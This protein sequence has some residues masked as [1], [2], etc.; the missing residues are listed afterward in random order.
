MDSNMDP[1]EK[2]IKNKLKKHLKGVTGST[3]ETLVNRV[4][5][6][7]Y[8]RVLLIT[9]IGIALA[10]NNLRAAV[11]MLKAAPEVSRLV[12]GSDMRVWGE[13]GKRLSATSADAAI[14]F[15]RASGDTLNVIVEDMR[16][17]VLRLVNKQAALS[18]NT[19]V[20]SFKSAPEIIGSIG[21]HEIVAQVL[22]ICLELARH[23]VKHS[24]DL[25]LD[26]PRVLA[27]LRS[28]GRSEGDAQIKRA[29]AL[30]S[31]FA[32]RSGGTAAEF[33]A[34]LPQVTA[35][36]GGES[37]E[38]LF[39]ITEQ[40][41]DRSGGVALQYFKAAS[42]VLAVAGHDSFE[43]WSALAQRVALQG[44]AAS[45]HFMKASPQIIS[46]LA[47]RAKPHRRA[48][49]V[50][51]V[52]EVIEEIAERNTAAA[53]ECFKASPIALA[54]ASLGQ[55][56]QWARKG[57]E[58]AS[59]TPRQTQAYY[60]LESKAS[61]EALLRI[62][63]GLTLDAV[64][65]TL[66]LY[67]EGLTGRALN[68]APLDSIPDEAKIGDGKTIYLP[69]VVAE[70]DDEDENFRLFKV[71]AAH[72]AGQIEF[73]TYIQ[74]APSLLAALAEVREAFKQ[75]R[76]QNEGRLCVSSPTIR[77]GFSSS[78]NGR[79]RDA[80]KGAAMP[81]NGID[82]LTVLSEFPNAELATRLFSTIENGRIDFLLR[83]VYRGIRRDLDFVRARLVE[84]RPHIEDVPAELVP[85]ELLFQVAICG[86][87]TDEA[88][89]LFPSVIG[90]LERVFA[91]YILREDASVADSL[92][93]T[94]HI[95]DFFIERPTQSDTQNNEPEGAGEEGQG[96]QAASADAEQSE[97]QQQIEVRDDPFSY[98]ASGQT[99]E[100]APDHDLFNQLRRAESVEQD[101]EKGD[102]AFYYDEWDRELGDYRTRWCR[103]IERGSA[104]GSRGFVE[105]VRSR[106]AGIISSVRYQFQLLRPENL[107]R[108]RGEIDGEDYDLQAVIDYALDKRSTGLIDDRLYTRKL[109]RERDVAVSFL[110]D[111]SSSTARTISRFPNHPYTQPG[112]RIIDIEKEGLVLMS[113]ALEAV[114]DI[115][116]MQGFT[117]EGRRNVKFYV[118]KDFSEGYST[119]VER[120][121][122]GITYQNN[123]RLG[124]AIRHA[125]TRLARQ[126]SRT[127]L[128]IVLSD[129][130][131]YDH[132]Y[133]D[134]R[135]AREDTRMA[136][137]QA[138]LEGII[139]FC[140]TI[141]RESEDQLRDMYG[142][143]GYT[144][145]DDVLS[146]PERLPGI[147]SRLTT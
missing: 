94:R 109:R 122:G 36:S 37:L 74:D 16:S 1:T 123:T 137:R 106:Y 73:E 76:A 141:D 19:A 112:Q 4:G 14:E 29:L 71:I 23:S 125:T 22:T 27:S 57:L 13:I 98:W 124:A 45:Y 3:L 78:G 97:L 51:S 110:L 144:I 44:N 114:G 83:S 58:T 72:A 11:E 42:R 70:F 21:D 49:V 10:A 126:D 46:D 40:Y 140:I 34:E 9:D 50:S 146:L 135:Y 90:D 84:R 66:R 87:A 81:E 79:K 134:S 7:P 115:Y 2:E 147:Y 61:Q 101:L 64:A 133:G 92:I 111:M 116:S 100:I 6:L 47:A 104:R 142:E 43:R 119:D 60:A 121:I 128:L 96:E 117:S 99:E 95:Y 75:R 118:I 108:I 129:G 143:I 86:G 93:A 32:F 24:N 68:V 145:I 82:F 103:I 5:V 80:Q 139:P 85:F 8:E 59:A 26:A 39:S 63:G 12:D 38:K 30:T 136:L 65:H 138:R 56:R 69:S 107:R 28:A 102:R 113:E 120:R 89:S 41:L 18:S 17:P 25:F 132:D 130:R 105:M 127:K 31:A 53:V 20:E 48:L 15:F 55:F 88:R 54:S 33:F 62:E 67:V 131:P 91:D 52:L 77:E 35:S